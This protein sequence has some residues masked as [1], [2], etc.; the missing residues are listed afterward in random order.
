[1]Y[2]KERNYEDAALSMEKLPTFRR[3]ATRPIITVDPLTKISRQSKVS[4]TKDSIKTPTSPKKSWT[5]DTLPS[6]PDYPLEAHGC[7]IIDNTD[8]STITQRLEEYLMRHSIVAHYDKQ[9]NAK[10]TT[11]CQMKFWIHLYQ[12]E[13]ANSVTVE[14]QRW[15]NCGIAFRGIRNDLWKVAKGVFVEATMTDTTDLASRCIKRQRTCMA[16]PLPSNLP[17]V[18]CKDGNDDDEATIA[19]IEEAVE[20]FQ[21]NDALAQRNEIQALSELSNA[22][23]SHAQT[24]KRFA[25]Q[26]L[27]HEVL[28]N[29]LCTR[30]D[31]ARRATRFSLKHVDP[32]H[33]L[34]LSLFYTCLWTLQTEKELESYIERE[35]TFVSQELLRTLLHQSSQVHAPHNA[36]LGTKGVKVLLTSSNALKQEAMELNVEDILNRAM[37]CGQ[38]C[39]FGLVEEAN[40]TMGLVR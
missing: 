4:P 10:C 19:R 36:W 22:D 26:I 27:S 23:I 8:A 24:A 13:E 14:I 37:N 29:I 18:D 1:M 35:Y 28:R 34:I 6:L 38:V 2:S 31:A 25:T 32:I 7:I 9:G 20:Q 3:A 33:Y 30:L 17:P 5:L 12:G 40:R 21:S 15:S 11:S 16:P 39:H